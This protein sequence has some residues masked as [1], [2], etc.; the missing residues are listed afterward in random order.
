M[1][2][3]KLKPSSVGGASSAPHIGIVGAGI[4]GLRAADILLQNGLEVTIFEARDRIGGRVGLYTDGPGVLV[5][6]ADDALRYA[7]VINLD[8]L[9]ICKWHI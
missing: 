9:W 3:L 4:S 7:R 5:A 8:I 2:E 1:G 6:L